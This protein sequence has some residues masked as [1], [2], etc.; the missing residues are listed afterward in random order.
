ML[1]ILNQ[2]RLQATPGVD[3]GYGCSDI[4]SGRGLQPCSFSPSVHEV[5]CDR[6]EVDKIVFDEKVNIRKYYAFRS[7]FDVQVFS[8][9]HFVE[10]NGRGGIAF[11][12][13]NL[14]TAK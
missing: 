9:L 5:T 10:N 1:R 8:D 12:K 3:F 7:Q 11:G 2:S 4:I 14:V 6:Y 13:C